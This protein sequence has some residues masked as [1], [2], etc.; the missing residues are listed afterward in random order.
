M[1]IDRKSLYLTLGYQCNNNC[2]ICAVS[3]HDNKKNI[4]STKEI[5]DFIN[6]A[7][8]FEKNIEKIEISGGEP[9][10][11][12]DFFHIM[13]H[14]KTNFPETHL[15]LLTNGRRF[16]NPQF[17]KKCSDYNFEDIII[18][19]H[20]PNKKIHERITRVKNSFLET[21][22]GIKN[23]LNFG[24]NASTKT[25]ITKI[26]YK[27]LPLIAEFVATN[28]GNVKRHTFHGLDICGNVKKNFKDVGIS[29]KKTKLMLEEAIDVLSSYGVSTGLYSIPYCYLDEYYWKFVL[30]QP[31]TTFFYKSPKKEMI[32]H[33]LNEKY[34]TQKKCEKCVMNVFCCGIWDSYYQKFGNEINPIL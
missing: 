25:I 16:S 24:M 1:G 20:G 2:I 32:N 11:R 15:Y 27:Y 7:K 34:G 14:I 28:F 19:V 29:M 12:K 22:R 17:T 4:M 30:P 33:M 26:N 21:M 18:A 3:S 8:I 5:I 10:I 31:K 13:N 23:I 6:K 9:T